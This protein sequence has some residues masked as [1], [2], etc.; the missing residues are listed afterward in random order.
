MRVNHRLLFRQHREEKLSVHK[1]G[2]CEQMQAA[3][4]EVRNRR[5][6]KIAA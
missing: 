4:R 2:S 3:C 6:S 5:M 1:H